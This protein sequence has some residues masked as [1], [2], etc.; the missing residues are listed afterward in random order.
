MA[1]VEHFG[2]DGMCSM[3]LCGTGIYTVIHS[4]KRKKLLFL[5]I[6]LIYVVVF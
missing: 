2:D 1:L 3:L 6:P 5:F 4:C